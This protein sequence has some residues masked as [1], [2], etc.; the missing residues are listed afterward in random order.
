MLI[1]ERTLN[2]FSALGCLYTTSKHCLRL[3]LLGDRG[4]DMIKDS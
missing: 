4:R 3:K 1:V 2:L